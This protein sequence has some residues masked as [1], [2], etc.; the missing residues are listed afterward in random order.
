MPL[1]FA[2]V[3]DGKR[4]QSEHGDTVKLNSPYCGK[5]S[6]AKELNRAHCIYECISIHRESGEYE[7]SLRGRFRGTL[8]MRS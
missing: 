5:C 3:L 1:T 4:A 7:R 8:I 6:V 2:F